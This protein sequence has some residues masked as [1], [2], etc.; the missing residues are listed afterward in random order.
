MVSAGHPHENGLPV[1]R[2]GDL[3]SAARKRARRLAREEHAACEAIC[4]QVRPA[5]YLARERARTRLRHRFP[6]RYLWFCTQERPGPG[7]GVHA[8]IRG[9]SWPRAVS[10]PA[11]LHA[12]ACRE[13]PARFR[14]RGVSQPGGCDRAMAI[15][16]EAGI[17]LF[18]RM[19]TEEYPGWLAVA[20]TGTR[21][22]QWGGPAVNLAVTG[23]G[24]RRLGACHEPG[25]P[26]GGRAALPWR[27]AEGGA[28]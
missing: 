28:V 7:T 18:T 15:L 16:R 13:L 25:G 26:R 11:D 2:G 5:G 6:A 22:C 20:G 17:G 27:V 14:A 10:R 8:G 1:S 12:P 4:E 23:P 9:K 19:L 3:S 21:E 24:G